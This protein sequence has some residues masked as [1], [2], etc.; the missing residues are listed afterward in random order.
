MA[1]KTNCVIG[2][3]GNKFIHVPIALATKERQQVDTHS[4]LWKGVLDA[5]RQN[6]YFYGK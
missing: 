3:I 5:T 1:G 6:D 2:Q 4:S